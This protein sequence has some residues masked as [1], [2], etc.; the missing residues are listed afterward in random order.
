LMVRLGL[1]RNGILVF[2]ETLEIYRLRPAQAIAWVAHK[3]RV[4]YAHAVILSLRS[5]A[6]STSQEK[7]AARNMQQ[8]FANADQADAL[9]RAAP[10]QQ[11]YRN[12]AAIRNLFQRLAI[13]IQQLQTLESCFMVRI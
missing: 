11:P 7:K 9:T 2:R 13:P 8:I 6:F 5:W 3:A 1:L 12:E 10:K 4:S